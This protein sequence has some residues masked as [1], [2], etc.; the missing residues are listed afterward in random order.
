M[1]LFLLPFIAGAKSFFGA[2]ITFC[3]KPPEVLYCHCDGH[4]DWDLVVWA[5]RVQQGRCIG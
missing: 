4:T 2:L 1:P 3:S 5:T